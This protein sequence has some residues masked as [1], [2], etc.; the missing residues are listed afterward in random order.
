MKEN[1]EEIEVERKPPGRPLNALDMQ[2]IWG[3]S[4]GF[5]QANIP[6]RDVKLSGKVA[7]KYLSKLTL[8]KQ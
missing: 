4:G 5:G 2:M 3:E 1:M 7:Q 8:Q 6:M